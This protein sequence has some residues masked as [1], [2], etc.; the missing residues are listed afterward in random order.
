MSLL[1]SNTY[2]NEISDRLLSYYLGRWGLS[3]VN[4]KRGPAGCTKEIRS[5]LDGGY[6]AMHEQAKLERAEIYWLNK[7]KVL[8]TNIWLEAGVVQRETVETEREQVPI[9][10]LSMLSVTSNQG[11]LLWVIIPGRID[12]ERQI[13]FV[14]ALLH[15]TRKKTIFLI[16]TSEK[17][18]NHRS[19]L[20]WINQDTNK[21]RIFPEKPV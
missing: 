1:I 21:V 14:Q 11:K 5:W 15:D 10:K 4:S 2:G 18:F 16:R 19:F 17:I 8:K 9:A 20:S 12:V 13:N 7:P 3:A 6:A